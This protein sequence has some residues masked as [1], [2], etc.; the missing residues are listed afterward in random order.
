MPPYASAATARQRTR[1]Q[2]YPGQRQPRGSVD[3]RQLSTAPALVG[4]TGIPRYFCGGALG[5][6]SHLL[7]FQKLIRENRMKRCRSDPK[8]PFTNPYL[9]ASHSLPQTVTPAPHWLRRAPVA[10]GRRSSSQ[11]SFVRLAAADP[12]GC[13]RIHRCREA[14]RFRRLSGAAPPLEIV[15]TAALT[16]IIRNRRESR[17]DMSA[18]TVPH[19]VR[20]RR[21]ERSR[22]P[23]TAARYRTQ[24]GW[25]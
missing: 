10:V 19:R 13:T 3:E 7:R 15:R 24:S 20:T 8:V 23:V 18:T 11:W 6:R 25:S 9:R 22:I 1:R 5:R 14:D 21:L 4:R 2:S 17:C 16:S 12:R